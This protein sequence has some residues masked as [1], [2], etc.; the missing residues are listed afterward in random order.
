M[1]RRTF[2]QGLGIGVLGQALMACQPTQTSG[3]RVETLQQSLPP[4]L[5]RQF[6]S[7]VRGEL[8]VSLQT[9]SAALFQILQR[10]HQSTAAHGT[11]LRL[12]SLGDFWLSEAIRQDLIQPLPVP[13]LA[14]WPTL[15][16]LWRQVGRREG[17]R[18]DGDQRSAQG[19]EDEP[20]WG[21]PY[22][23]GTT[24]IAYRRDKFRALGW[25]P[26][27]WNDLWRP[28]LEQ[29][30][31][32]LDQPREVIGLT[33]KSLGE[34]Y[35]REDLETVV[36]L[37]ERLAQL[38]RQTRFYDS[39]NYLQPL[40]LGDTWAAVGWS[41]DVLHT[42]SQEPKIKAVVPQ[43]GTALWADLWV[44]AALGNG[45]RSEAELGENPTVANGLGEN[46]VSQWIDYWWQPQVA[47]DLSRFTDAVSPLVSD[48]EANSAAKRLLLPQ[49]ATFGRS[50]FL[51]PL[52]AGAIAQYRQKW[53]QMRQS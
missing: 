9:Q 7:Q 38:H 5:V 8:T 50:E 10:W 35:N 1:D 37:R 48:P 43:S 52:S 29:R 2:I 12:V 17:L 32:L 24:V 4:Q 25:Q 18:A 15:P 44:W 19:S 26:Q 36:G 34:S 21:A 40:I 49:Q 33:L 6:R 3:L 27:D 39:T 47:N 53:Q 41:T 11:G 20:L 22:R 31:S 42:M 13:Q 23:W 46:L 14:Q 51:Q 28:E 30:V 45:Q 16:E